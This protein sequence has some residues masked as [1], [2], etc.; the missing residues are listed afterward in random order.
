[1]IRLR[2]SK[3]TMCIAAGLPILSYAKDTS[4]LEKLD[5][6]S[7][8][9][10]VKAH[11]QTDNSRI[12]LD[13]GAIWVSR[14]IMRFDPVLDLSISSDVEVK[15]G[16]PL[17]EMSFAI[18]TNFSYYVDH[19]Q[20][21]VFR[22]GDRGLVNPLAVV[23]GQQFANDFNIVWDGA[24]TQDYQFES[25]TQLLFRLKAFDKD[26]NMDVTTVGVIDLVEPDSEVDIDKNDGEEDQSRKLGKA[27]LMRHNIP[28]SAGLA[29]FMGT[30]LKGVDKV[31]IGE[32]EFDVEEGELYAEQYLPADAYLFP[33]RVVF[34]NGEER[35]YQLYVRI[36]DEYW[37]QAGLADFYIGKN[38]VT[39]NSAALVVDDQYQD[40]IYNQGRL[41]Y[42]GQGKFGDKLRITTHFDTKESDVR[43]M[44]KHP[45]ASD[46]S[47]VFDILEDDDEMY[48]GNYGD[49]SN[50]Y[51]VVNTKGK[52]YLNVEYDKSNVLWGNY[53]TGITGTDNNDYNRS[54]YG[55]KGD[56]RTRS[57]T[58]F[59]ED[60]LNIVGFAAES[61]S[62]FAHDEF[63]GTGGSLYFLRH[64]EVVPGSDKV[65]V[66]VVDPDSSIT[67]QEMPLQSGR[68][69]E[70][71]P[72]QATASF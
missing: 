35:R 65:M 61:D 20:L 66:K 7:L 54:L 22:G 26:G 72:Y 57:T 27:Q 18:T 15:D 51:K 12:Y 19:Y 58:K 53:N 64:G 9:I 62:L 1:M 71:D 38:K 63:L 16:K 41:A 31:V 25:N 40:D 69:Y 56:Y 45:F 37:V 11:E 10:E 49:S 17:Q 42:F 68:D 2:P 23:E 52:V 33:T 28:T 55:F 5:S 29:R 14:D 8:G 24:T 70:I 39:G 60:R 21:E 6:D 43:D 13:Q 4:Q 47:S 44:F 46:S 50:I 34:D 48:Y 32:D 3:L 30:G 59:G 67:V 36:P